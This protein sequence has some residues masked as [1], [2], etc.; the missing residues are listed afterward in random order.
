MKSRVLSRKPHNV[1]SVLF[2]HGWNSV[3][4]GLKPSYLKEHGLT[5]ID[6]ELCDNDFEAA[7]CIAQVAFDACRPSVGVGSSRGGAVAMNLVVGDARLVLLCPAWKRWGKA[8]YVDDSTILIHSR[9]DEVIPFTDSED[10]LANSGLTRAN[11]IEVG[12]DHRLADSGSL[13]AMLDAV[14]TGNRNV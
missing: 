11:L 14:L 13:K 6:P 8:K 1:M 2:L 5:V 12:N 4:G 10:L 7:L 3:P 9:S